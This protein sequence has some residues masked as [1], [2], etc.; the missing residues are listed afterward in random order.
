MPN[1]L[2][3]ISIILY[4]LR[5]S[6]LTYEEKLKRLY[7]IGYRS[8]QSGLQPNISNT[9]NKQLIMDEL[10]MEVSCFSGK[11]ED[12]EL[13]L[14]PYIEGCHVFSC[15]E[16]MIGTMPTEC[17]EDYDGYMHAVDRI[18][19]IG[20]TLAQEGIFIGYHNHAQEFRRFKEGK[21]G[22]EL[23]YENLDPKSVHFILDTHWV[24]AGG[25]DV[26][27]WIEKCRGRTRYLHVKDYCI[28]PANYHTDIACADKRFAPV[29]GGNLPW[30]LIIDTALC[31]GVKAF[32]VEQDFT[33]GEDPFQCAAESFKT[34]KACG[35]D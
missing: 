21:T 4:G 5:F 10:G 2:S 32:I 9:E 16:I 20:H 31:I 28:A 22:M 8:I 34:L 27:Q 7:E 12:M 15:D 30:Q 6:T 17:R 24:Q 26:I 19:A 25:G 33:Y 29:G 11:L 1:A 23:L 35:L 14:R 18:N 13:D 3:N